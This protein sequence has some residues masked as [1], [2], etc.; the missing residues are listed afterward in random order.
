MSELFSFDPEVKNTYSHPILELYRDQISAKLDKE[1]ASLDK[2]QKEVCAVPSEKS[3]KVIANAGS[4]KTKVLITRALKMIIREKINP[5]NLVLITFTNRASREIRSRFIEFFKDIVKDDEELEMVPIPNI[6]TIHSFGFNSLFRV[7]NIHRTILSEYGGLRLLKTVMTECLDP[8]EKIPMGEVKKLYE[9]IDNFY[10]RNEIH[11]VT[12]TKMTSEGNF[13]ASHSLKNAFDKF[14]DEVNELTKLSF[15]YMASDT[16]KDLLTK[17]GISELAQELI[18]ESASNCDMGHNMFINIVTRFIEDRCK[19]GAMTFS[20][21]MYLP[22][23]LTIQHP[24]LKKKMENMYKYFSMDESQDNDN[25]NFGFI[26]T[27]AGKDPSIMLVGDSKQTLF[28]WRNANPDILEN[29]EKILDTEV[30]ET[31]LLTNYRSPKQHVILSNLFSNS[32]RGKTVHHSEPFNAPIKGS[33]HLSN[34]D[35]STQEMNFI[36]TEILELVKQG[37]KYSDIAVL[38]RT[39]KSLLNIEAALISYGIPNIPKHDSRSLTRMST[40]KFMFSIYSILLN[41]KDINSLI[42]IL[43][44]VKGAGAKMNDEVYAKFMSNLNTDPSFN[45]FKMDKGNFLTGSKKY[46][47]IY[48]LINH[49]LV[50]IKKRFQTPNISLPALNTDIMGILRRNAL[51][52]GDTFNDSF[53]LSLQF[54]LKALIKVMNTFDNIYNIMNEEGTLMEMTATEK[55]VAV[56]ETLQLSQDP[57]K[58]G[59]DQDKV[60]ISTIHAYKGKE[61]DA[62]FFCNLNRLQP[63]PPEDIE[64]ERCCFYVGVTRAKKK[65]IPI[66][67]YLYA[68]L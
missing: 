33:I 56:Y 36:G 15:S 13:E 62:I 23:V 63:V 31:Q 4:G 67:K 42:E 14:P 34:Y 57:N 24:S 53:Y 40:F 11:L 28:T 61:A 39:N 52:E 22:Q 12:Y 8:E 1:I 54:D 29:F 38:S 60:M 50:P 44:S 49:I 7:M 46:E 51:L 16:A 48:N 19:T 47:T 27:I 21:C 30:V 10:A 45:I 58:D 6:S 3:I 43:G 35:K 5:S 65:A 26:K 55:F 17:E 64:E 20:D 41:H 37:Y 68:G 32:F 2:F 66:L 18:S 59:D 9:E 25:L